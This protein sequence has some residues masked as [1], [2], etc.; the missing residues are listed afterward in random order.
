MADTEEKKTIEL[1]AAQ[2]KIVEALNK[3]S[4]LELSE[5]VKHL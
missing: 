4:A 2:K 3:L 1:N 5:V